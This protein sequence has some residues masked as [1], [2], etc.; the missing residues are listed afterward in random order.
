MQP[1]ICPLCTTK[2][3]KVIEVIKSQDLV[4]LYAKTYPM[5]ISYLFPQSELQYCQCTHCQLKYFF[6]S[7]IGDENFYNTL[8]ATDLYYM[9]DK[10]EYEFA[11]KFVREI[12][13]VLEIG[14]GK[15]AFS[16]KIKCKSYTGLELSTNAK[17]LAEQGGVH[18]LNQT[19]QEHAI[20]NA[21]KYD[22]VCTFQVLEHVKCDELFSFLK[23]AVE[24]LKD[25]GRLIISVPSADSFL[26]E[27]VNSTLNLP[28]HHQSH[29]PD[30]AMKEIAKIFDLDMLESAHDVIAQQNK[31]EYLH[32]KL[33]RFLA[34]EQRLIEPKTNILQKIAL[35]L[36]RLVP[37]RIQFF[38]IDKIKPYGHSITA[39]YKKR[40]G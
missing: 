11:S 17:K 24:C 10:E 23:A 36:L 20:L 1:T 21:K 37:M 35:R 38:I 40:R 3:A 15:G 29:W 31:R 18:I 12:D 26:S 30:K 7:F 32:V 16:K 33:R 39:V 28:P 6:P 13:D 27:M 2:D 34:F 9:D 19:I 14:C 4:D 22:A 8:Q 5:N 25:G